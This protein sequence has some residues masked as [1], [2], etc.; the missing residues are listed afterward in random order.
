V[1]MSGA[2]EVVLRREELILSGQ[3]VIG[4]GQSPSGEGAERVEFA[5][6]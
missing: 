5:C 3:G 1:G 2:D 4:F 6:Q